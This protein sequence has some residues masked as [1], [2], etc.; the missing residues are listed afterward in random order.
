[1]VSAQNPG[2]M[3]PDWHPIASG[4][5]LALAFMHG[6]RCELTGAK[7]NSFCNRSLWDDRNGDGSSPVAA[8]SR[9]I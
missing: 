2:R 9:G 7:I 3:A 6:R 1:M 4:F 5:V 8:M